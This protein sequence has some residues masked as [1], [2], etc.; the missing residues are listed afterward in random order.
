VTLSVIFLLIIKLDGEIK[1]NVMKS[2]NIHIAHL[3]SNCSHVRW[4]IGDAQA[5]RFQLR[6]RSY[7]RNYARQNESVS[8]DNDYHGGSVFSRKEYNEYP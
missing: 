7:L 2:S 3:N 5:K 8:C 6:Q 1:V 4:R